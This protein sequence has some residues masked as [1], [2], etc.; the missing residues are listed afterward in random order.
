M[1]T[2]TS[3]PQTNPAA[4]SYDGVP[5]SFTYNAFTADPSYCDLQVTCKSV[6]NVA[7]SIGLPCQELVNGRLTWTISGLDYERGLLPGTYTYTFEVTTAPGVAALTKTFTVD[8]TLVDPCL[9]ATINKPTPENQTYVLGDRAFSYDLNPEFTTVPSFCRCTITWSS[10]GSPFNGLQ[11]V[12]R[13]NEDTQTFYFDSVNENVVGYINL[14]GSW[15]ITVVKT[16]QDISGNNSV[17]DQIIFNYIVTS[18]CDDPSRYTLTASSQL[19]FKSDAYTGTQVSYKWNPYSI[20]PS[21]CPI[22]L[23]CTG[24]TPAIAAFQCQELVNNDPNRQTLNWTVPSSAWTNKTI[25]PGTY[26]TCY[27]VR[28]ASQTVT[29]FCIDFTVVDPCDPPQIT[30]PDSNT[31]IY[32]ITDTNEGRMVLASEYRVTPSWC[33]YTLGFI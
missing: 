7:G 33:P 4:N 2:I 17:S 8:V 28:V 31:L 14:I 1:T 24:V 21:Y 22:T 16:V 19:P 6:S 27:D 5:F 30:E 26:K 29:N 11:Q 32:T 25:P 23:T 18:P 20:S 13:F 9:T 12:A 3:K 15:P 10:V